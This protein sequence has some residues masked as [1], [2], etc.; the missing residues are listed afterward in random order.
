MDIYKDNLLENNTE[1]NEVIRGRNSDFLLELCTEDIIHEVNE[2]DIKVFLR[3]SEDH[4][5]GYC[6]DKD[7]LS[8]NNYIDHQTIRLI[9]FIM[10]E[11]NLEGE[12]IHSYAYCRFRQIDSISV[13]IKFFGHA[14]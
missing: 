6:A 13:V 11:M 4:L 10:E 8:K 1:G 7:Y 2:D 9:K 5:S 14:E 12:D 3:N